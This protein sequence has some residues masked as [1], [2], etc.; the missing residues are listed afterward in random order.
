MIVY[1][2]NPSQ[3]GGVLYFINLIEIYKS[4]RNFLLRLFFF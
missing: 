4:N 1:T 3:V 2:N